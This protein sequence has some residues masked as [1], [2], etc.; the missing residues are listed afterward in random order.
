MRARATARQKEAEA[1]AE[2]ESEAA[3]KA[4]IAE[5]RAGNTSAAMEKPTSAARWSEEKGGAVEDGKKRKEKK[6]EPWVARPLSAHT[7]THSRIGS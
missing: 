6:C 1:E 5:R 2:S 3:A 4:R 7:Y